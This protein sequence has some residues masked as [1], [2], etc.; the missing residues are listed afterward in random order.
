MLSVSDRTLRKF[1]EVAVL[2]ILV[3]VLNNHLQFC[4][5]LFLLSLQFALTC[6]CFEAL[7]FFQRVMVIGLELILFQVNEGHKF[8]VVGDNY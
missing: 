4:V 6:L 5:P 2:A 7:D 3:V 1:T 8:I